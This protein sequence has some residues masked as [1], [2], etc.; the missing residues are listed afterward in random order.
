LPELAETK[1]FTA[2]LIENESL[3]IKSE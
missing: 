2:W 3:I 1:E